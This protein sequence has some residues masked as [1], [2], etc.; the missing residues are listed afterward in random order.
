MRWLLWLTTATVLLQVANPSD[1]EWRYQPTVLNGKPTR[2]VF[3]VTV[4]FSLKK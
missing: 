4:E 1:V 2:V 3:E